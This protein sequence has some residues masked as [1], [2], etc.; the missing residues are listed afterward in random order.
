VVFRSTN[1]ASDKLFILIVRLTIA[2]VCITFKLFDKRLK[3]TG[4]MVN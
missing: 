3:I 1:K 4:K 2:F